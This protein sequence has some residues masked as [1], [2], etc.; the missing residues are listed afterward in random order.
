MWVP[1]RQGFVSIRTVWHVEQGVRMYTASIRLDWRTPRWCV[2]ANRVGHGAACLRA[3]INHLFESRVLIAGDSTNA[4][5]G[6]LKLASDAR[7]A[8][9]M[10]LY[11]GQLFCNFFQW[12]LKEYVKLNKLNFL[13]KNVKVARFLGK[14]WTETHFPLEYVNIRKRSSP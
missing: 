5:L 4:P 14:K 7:R 9:G 2:R 6:A 3:K 13:I 8:L 12:I 10:C 11:C 1:K